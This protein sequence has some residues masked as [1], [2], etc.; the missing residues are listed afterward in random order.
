MYAD[1]GVTTL[2]RILCSTFNLSPTVLQME[3]S[4]S[5]PSLGRAYMAVD[6]VIEK[7]DFDK[8]A[9]VM[10]ALDWKWMIHSS[11][12][13]RRPTIDEM[14]IQIHVLFNSSV[15]WMD[16]IDKAVSGSGGFNAIC[17]KCKDSSFGYKLTIEFTAVSCAV[18]V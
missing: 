10:D 5:A 15:S 18:Y 2:L 11:N 17:E 14:K 3:T 6:D 4:A 16:R 8:V 9:K 1:E 12:E 7:F 13:F